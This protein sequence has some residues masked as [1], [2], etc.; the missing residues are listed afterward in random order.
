MPNQVM[1][2]F[3]HGQAEPTYFHAARSIRMIA[4]VKGTIARAS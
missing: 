1:M 2:L 4:K 3:R